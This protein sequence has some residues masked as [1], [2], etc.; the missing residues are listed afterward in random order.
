MR[1]NNSNKTMQG[2]Q[3]R[4]YKSAGLG[5]TPKRRQALLNDGRFKRKAVIVVAFMMFTY[6]AFTFVRLGYTKYMVSRDLENVSRITK[7]LEKKK[8]SLREKIATSE[9]I[10]GRKDIMRKSGRF[11]K[12]ESPFVIYD[13]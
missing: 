12:N 13:H 11:P 6:L 4:A 5:L 8:H 1:A 2:K 10:E 9:T 7:Q 3:R